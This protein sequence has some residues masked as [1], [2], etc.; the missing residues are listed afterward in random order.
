MEEGGNVWSPT[1][2]ARGSQD[3][4]TRGEH[5]VPEDQFTHGQNPWS[6]WFGID[7]FPTKFVMGFPKKRGDDLEIVAS[8]NEG[9]WDWSFIS[10]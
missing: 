5:P 6:S 2:K 3:T 9:G 7:A 1:G 10:F 8:T 4:P